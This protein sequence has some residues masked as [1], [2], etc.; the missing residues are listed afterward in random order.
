MEF[1]SELQLATVSA[2]VAL[3]V[4][5]SVAVF[6]HGPVLRLIGRLAG[7][8]VRRRGLT[9]LLLG[10]LASGGIAAAN[11]VGLEPPAATDAVM[12]FQGQIDSWTFSE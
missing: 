2:A 8:A 3:V 7:F 11:A 12:W 6:G 9:T 5:G 4:G 10:S 1:T